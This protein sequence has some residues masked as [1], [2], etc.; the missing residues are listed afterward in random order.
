[1]ADGWPTVVSG[2][3]YKRQTAAQFFGAQPSQP[4]AGGAARRLPPGRRRTTD[5]DEQGAPPPQSSTFRPPA[6]GLKPAPGTQF[7]S[8]LDIE[9]PSGQPTSPM[10]D[11]V[12]KRRRG[13]RPPEGPPTPG[14]TVPTAIRTT[15]GAARQPAPAGWENMRQPAAGWGRTY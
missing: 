6:P 4:A 2:Q 11:A 9:G 14:Q 3:P 8:P 5:P 10:G 1:M 7:P 15:V 13:L 12:R